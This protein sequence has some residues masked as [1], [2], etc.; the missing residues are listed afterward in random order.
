MLMLIALAPAL[1]WGATGIVTTK[2]GGKAIQ[3]TLGMAYG[4]VL[5]G[6]GTLFFF[7]IPHAGL[8]YAF[9]PRIWLVGIFSG[10]FWAVGSVGQFESFKKIGVSIGN[11]ISTAGQIITNALMAAIVLGEWTTLNMW[12]FGVISI[13]M[14]TVGAIFTAVTDKKDQS[15]TKIPADKFRQGMY[16][17]IISTVGFMFYFVFPNLLNKI[18]FISNAVHSTPNGS[19]LYYMTAII[20]PQAVG[21][22]IGALL[23]ITFFVKEPNLIFDKYTWRNVVTGIV[24]AIGNIFMFIAAG[25]PHIGQAVATTLSQCGVIVGTFGG[26]FILSEK[27]TSRQMVYVTIGSILIVIGSILISNLSSLHW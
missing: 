5:L 21:Q 22:L 9:N 11:P 15:A 16:A 20:V 3:G 25:N 7:V 10:L 4:S 23:I 17:I 13:A 18:G 27:K 26:I 6:L 1:F 24:W 14:V 12:T 2:A 19:G 8:A